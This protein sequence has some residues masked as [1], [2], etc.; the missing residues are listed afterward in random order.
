MRSFITLLVGVL[1]SAAAAW[2]LI[3][4]MAEPYDVVFMNDVAINGGGAL[5]ML[6]GFGL[7]VPFGA[8][9]AFSFMLLWKH[10][11]G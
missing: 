7:A 4:G 9:A 5:G 6:L 11:K 3:S 1:A 8:I 2:C 10:R